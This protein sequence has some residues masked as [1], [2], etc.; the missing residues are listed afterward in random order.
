MPAAIR[1]RAQVCP[2][3]PPACT[4]SIVEMAAEDRSGH[5]N[6]L[7]GGRDSADGRWIHLDANRRRLVMGVSARSEPPATPPARA[8]PSERLQ[9][10]SIRCGSGTSARSRPDGRRTPAGRS[11]GPS[12]S[13]PSGSVTVSAKAITAGPAPSIEAIV[14]RRWKGEFGA[15]VEFGLG[16]A[17]R[18]P[19]DHRLH[20]R[21]TGIGDH[22]HRAALTVRSHQHGRRQPSPRPLPHRPAVR[23]DRAGPRCRAGSPPR[24]HRPR[25][26]RRPASRRPRGP[27]TSTL[28]DEF[29]TA[30]G[31]D[32]HPA[33]TP[34]PTP[35]RS[36]SAPLSDARTLVKPHSAQRKSASG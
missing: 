4:T 24:N 11:T 10:N 25:P 16:V 3:T 23:C 36:G 35:R 19:P 13:P 28:F 21:Q 7:E 15:F 12:T 5:P 18:I 33:E 17:D 27:R 6:S 14:H 30:G 26:V 1:R 31:Q 2:Q 22:H 20:R 34:V 32:R 29:V 8:R 9:R